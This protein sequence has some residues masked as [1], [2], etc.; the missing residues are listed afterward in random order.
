MRDETGSGEHLGKILIDAGV[1][2]EAQLREALLHQQGLDM[3]LG[4][5]LVE[6]GFC[7][8]EEVTSAYA[9]QTGIRYVKIS[10]FNIDPGLVE[11]IPEEFASR[12]LI[13]PVHD[14]NDTLLLAMVDPGD[15][16]VIRAVGFFLNCRVEPVISSAREIRD[17][18]QYYYKGAAEPPEDPSD[19]DLEKEEELRKLREFN[20][21]HSEYMPTNMVGRSSVMVELYKNIFK[22]ANSNATVLLLGESGTGKEVIAEAI[23]N[24][25]RRSGNPFIKV[26]CAALPESLLESELFG[27]E[28]GA[29]TGAIKRKLGRFELAHG[30]TLFLDEIGEL[31][32]NIQVKLLRV[33]QQRMITRLGGMESIHIDVRILAATNR[34][35]IQAVQEGVFRNDLYYRLNVISF[36]IPPL[37]KRREDI[38]LLVDHFLNIYR[39]RERKS[40]SRLHPAVMDLMLQYD[41]PGNVRELENSVEHAVVMAEGPQILAQHLPFSIQSRKAPA[42]E[43]VPVSEG[44]MYLEIMERQ[45]IM[46]ALQENHWSMN[47]TS[48]VLGIHRNTLRRKMGQYG[49]SKPTRGGE[50]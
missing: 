32:L 23:H 21:N 49:I 4:T 34:N 16:D 42:Y 30:G 26:S 18:I 22:V 31:S 41:W 5:I 9:L 14:K 46:H 19:I 7:S 45:Q 48:Q 37:R 35:L 38:P 12:H 8:V 11:R 3:P 47:R 20:D 44:G 43:E 36:L 33:L 39:K 28:K 50:V 27:H 24:A 2:T 40:I 1:I 15:E 13:F 29:F 6:K 25:S 10:D 17:A